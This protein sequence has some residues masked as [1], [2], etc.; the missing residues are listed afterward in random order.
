MQIETISREEA[1]RQQKLIEQLNENWRKRFEAVMND[2]AFRK[3][4][5]EQAIAGDASATAIDKVASGI[6]KFLTAPILDILD[7][8]PRE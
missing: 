3:W 7:D 2:I 6:Y 4:C 8:S 1:A 5:V